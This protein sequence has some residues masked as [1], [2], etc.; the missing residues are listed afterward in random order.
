MDQYGPVFLSPPEQNPDFHAF[1]EGGCFLTKC[2]SLKHVQFNP[3]R[4]TL[5]SPSQ[6]PSQLEEKVT[7]APASQRGLSVPSKPSPPRAAVPLLLCAGITACLTDTGLPQHCWVPAQP[8]Q[9]QRACWGSA[10]GRRSSGPWA[11]EPHTP[12]A[13]WLGCSS[14]LK[15]TEP[16]RSLQPSTGR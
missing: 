4:L 10:G 15:L 16:A 12:S 6:P 3:L 14:P 11:W 7:F 1:W 5:P 8:L 9:W 2:S 13:A